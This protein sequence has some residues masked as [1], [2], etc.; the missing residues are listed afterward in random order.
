VLSFSP[1]VGIGI[2]PPPLPEGECVPT[3]FGSGGKGGS[4]HSVGGEGVG[5]PIPT[6][7]QTLLYSRYYLY[8]V[9]QRLSL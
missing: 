7:G 9:V 8:F 4:T 2:L 6:R 3:S 5:G 1:V